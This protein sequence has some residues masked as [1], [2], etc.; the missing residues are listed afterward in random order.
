MYTI[1]MDQDLSHLAPGVYQ[2]LGKKT[3]W[4][5]LTKWL[6]FPIFLFLVATAL[7][8]ARRSGLVSIEY[9]GYVATASLIF[10]GVGVLA[11][12]IALLSCRFV[13]KSHSFCL[14]E[15]AFKMKKGIITK[16]EMAIPY[17]QIQNVEIHRTFTQQVF[18]VSRLVIVTAGSDDS[19]TVH[20]ESTGVLPTIDRELAV[21]LQT[22]L[23]K[24]SDV[25]RVVGANANAK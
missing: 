10:L 4:L 1:A 23:I 17:R 25:Q 3:Y 14:S 16:Q 8:F 15:D 20:N 11:L 21:A 6:N 22:E 5:F 24:R 13:Y 18:G 2:T 7:L 12:M 19:K 9:Q